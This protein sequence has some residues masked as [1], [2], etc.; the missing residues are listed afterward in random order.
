MAEGDSLY[1]RARADAVRMFESRPGLE[2]WDWRDLGSKEH[3]LAFTVAKSTGYNI[4]EDIRDAL[5]DPVVNRGSFE[6]FRKRLTPILQQKGWWGRKEAVDPLTGEVSIVQLGSP[7][8]L[9]TIYW[10]N[11]ATAEAVGEWHQIQATKEFLPYLT[12]LISLSENKRREHLQFVGV[13]LPV[14]DP[15]W[16]TYFPPNGWKC[17]CRA[18]QIS[19]PKAMRV[20][21][22]SRRPP[23]ER[24]R[25]WRNGR[26]GE[27]RRVPE[28]IDPGWD[29]NPGIMAGRERTLGKALS[30]GLDR[31]PPA[32]RREAVQKL[33]DHPL[34]RDVAGSD[35]IRE[36]HIPVAVLPE[37]LMKPIGAETSIVRA[38]GEIGAKSQRTGKSGAPHHPEATPESYKLV[39]P[40]LDIGRVIQ[41]G[42]R[43]L[44]VDAPAGNGLWW[45]ASLTATA[46]G[47]EVFLS[48]WFMVREEL[49]ARGPQRPHLGGGAAKVLYEHEE[50]R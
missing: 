46:D 21:E 24:L 44:L 6:E 12:Y 40:A 45:R 30:D 11:V 41:E 49:Y 8:R 29:H 13:T 19:G 16:R 7:R 33:L 39:Q 25:E 32:P 36:N 14:D 31:L 23:P 27:V 34:I 42:D 38:S 17:K 3:V 43:K 20:P 28:G 1:K 2:S 5:R 22:E 15:W 4:I 9:R 47:A 26:T 48:T 37:S 35:G 10:A 18:R 50:E